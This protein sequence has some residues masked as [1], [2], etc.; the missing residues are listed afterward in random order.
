[1]IKLWLSETNVH[2]M[3]YTTMKLYTLAS[4]VTTEYNVCKQEYFVQDVPWAA[5]EDY[6][7]YI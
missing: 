1:M 6:I 4:R 2:K 5:V 7:N 3:I